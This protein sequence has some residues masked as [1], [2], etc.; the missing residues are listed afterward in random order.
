LTVRI[1]YTD[2]PGLDVSD[3]GSSS[4]G[5]YRYFSRS[6]RSNFVFLVKNEQQKDLLSTVDDYRDKNIFTLPMDELTA[7]EIVSGGRTYRFGTT[8][9]IKG[10]RLSVPA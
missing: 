2:G 6:D 10:F 5:K 1:R 8:G 7:V 3:G 4:D 9:G